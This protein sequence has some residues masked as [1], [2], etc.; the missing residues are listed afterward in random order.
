ML[1]V[2]PNCPRRLGRGWGR[3]WGCCTLSTAT[4]TATATATNT[5]ALQD[6]PGARPTPCVRVGLLLATP[7]SGHAAR[8]SGKQTAAKPSGWNEGEG[9]ARLRRQMQT[10]ERRLPWAESTPGCRG[11]TVPPCL[12]LQ[13]GNFPARGVL[14]DEPKCGTALALG[15]GSHQDMGHLSGSVG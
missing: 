7:P 9:Q 10:Q 8:R 14:G 12:P 1:S 5:A 2:L 13:N 3:P 15:Q 6:S 11:T 4:A